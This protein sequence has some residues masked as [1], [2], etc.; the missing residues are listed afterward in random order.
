[1]VLPAR[2]QL[3]LALGHRQNTQEAAA[4]EAVQD[5]KQQVFL[6]QSVP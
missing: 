1:M 4:Q 5:H 3:A 6:H 2:L